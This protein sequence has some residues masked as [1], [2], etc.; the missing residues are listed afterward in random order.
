MRRPLTLAFLLAVVCWTIGPRSI[1]AQIPPFGGAREYVADL[2][3]RR[4]RILHA[5]GSE[6]VLVLWSAP[7]RVYSADIDYE[8]RQE[9]NLLYLTGIDQEETILVL[10]PGGRTTRAVLFVH[11]G[12]PTSALWTGRS[13]TAAEAADRS[14]IATV[15]PQRGTEAFDAFIAALVS[16]GETDNGRIATDR[17]GG[18]VEADAR[19]LAAKASDGFAAA[20]RAGQARLGVLGRVPPASDGSE[21]LENATPGGVGRDSDIHVQW[22]RNLQRTHA[23]L[24]AFSADAMFANARQT[25][26]PYEQAVLKRSVE[27]SA[28]AQVA[29]MKAAR[30][31]RWEYEVEA[32]VEH[33][34]LAH[35]AMSWGYPSI[36]A[37]GPN[38]TTLH[39]LKSTRQMRDGDLLLVDAAGNFQG[40]TGDITRTYPVNGRFSDSQRAIYALVLRAQ[41]AGIAAARP[42]ARIAD[43]TAAVRAVF[44]DGLRGLGLVVDLAGS[45]T[46]SAQVS[47]WFPHGPVHGIGVDVHDSLDALNPGAAFVIEPG[48]YI[49]EDT[50]ENLSRTN[51]SLAARLR[52]AT[53]RFRNVG[54]RIEDSFLMTESGPVMMSAAAPRTI[55]DIERVV[56]T[57]P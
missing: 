15:I 9:S 12:D 50:L 8:Y 22:A 33:W 3:A 16:G 26:T 23:G 56:G 49:R 31:G 38:A 55:P 29:G 51:A 10:I 57:G 7:L 14:G 20:M 6:T 35:G 17:P 27:I 48:L 21:A 11:Q 18:E 19:A 1:A 46:E 36:V 45:L 43:V 40:L 24:T 4:A 34:N 2:T 37:S 54:V 25:K 44:A 42:G 32:A 28:Q 5:L 47:L 53:E 13:L 30:P 52:P 39:Y 41:D